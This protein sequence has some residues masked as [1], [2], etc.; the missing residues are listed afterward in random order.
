MVT[1]APPPWELLK[2]ALWLHDLVA[3]GRERIIEALIAVLM[4]C[5]LVYMKFSCTQKP[6]TDQNEYIISAA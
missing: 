5:Q 3:G 6:L 1:A 2:R 4:A